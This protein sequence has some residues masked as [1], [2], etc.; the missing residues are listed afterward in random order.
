V[1]AAALDAEY[2]ATRNQVAVACADLLRFC[3][4]ADLS[5]SAIHR[6]RLALDEL[7]G[8]VVAH[9]PAQPGLSFG[10]SARIEGDEL[11]VTVSS[12]GPGVDP[13]TEAAPD[14]EGPLDERAPGRLGLVL[15]RAVVDRLEHR[16]AGGRNLTT[17]AI[18]FAR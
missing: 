17:F 12:D 1:S 9:G 15:L 5:A 8:N 3:A 16:A 14:L 10:V 13:R 4:I 18:R 7:A 11:E 2:A 6:A